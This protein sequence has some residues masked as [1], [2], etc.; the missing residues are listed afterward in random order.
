MSIIQFPVNDDLT[1]YE[2]F[3]IVRPTRTT[4]YHVPAT[5][6]ARDWRDLLADVEEDTKLGCFDRWRTSSRHA[7]CAC[8]DAFGPLASTVCWMRFMLEAKAY[9]ITD[10]LRAADVHAF[11]QHLTAHLRVVR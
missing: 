4:R 7:T 2:P 10:W 8:H 3:G 11:Q 5:S 9:G 6:R 1:D